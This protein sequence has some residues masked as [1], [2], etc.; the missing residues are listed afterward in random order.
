MVYDST[1][2]LPALSQSHAIRV[3]AKGWTLPTGGEAHR[4]AQPSVWRWPHIADGQGPRA[5]GSW[6]GM[7]TCHKPVPQWAYHERLEIIEPLN[8]GLCLTMLDLNPFA[9]WI[10]PLVSCYQPQ[11]PSMGTCQGHMGQFMFT[12]SLF[13]FF[14]FCWSKSTQTFN[15]LLI[16]LTI[17]LA[18]ESSRL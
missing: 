8:A 15:S 14:Q 16:V 12:I 7:I 1:S 9:K 18:A 5:C 3:S 17:F 2:Y 10:L 13:R 11:I 4:A 6:L